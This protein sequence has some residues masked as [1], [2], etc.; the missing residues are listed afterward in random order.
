MVGP[1]LKPQAIKHIFFFQN[2]DNVMIS[3]FITDHSIYVLHRR[4]LSKNKITISITSFNVHL[5]SC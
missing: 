5:S 2:K 1:Y 4:V 3:L